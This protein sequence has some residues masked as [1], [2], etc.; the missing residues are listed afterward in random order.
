MDGGLYALVGI[1]VSGYDYSDYHTQTIEDTEYEFEITGGKANNIGLL[2]WT[3]TA[4]PKLD[5]DIVKTAEMSQSLRLKDAYEITSTVEIVKGYDEARDGFNRRVGG[6]DW[7]PWVNVEVH[8]AGQPATGNSGTPP[9]AA[10]QPQSDPNASDGNEPP[11]NTEIIFF[12][13]LTSHTYPF[14]GATLGLGFAHKYPLVPGWIS[15][16]FGLA[17]GVHP[18]TFVKILKAVWDIYQV[19]HPDEHTSD[20]DDDTGGDKDDDDYP[21]CGDY[22]I[23]I[24]NDFTFGS[25]T[26]R[27]FF[28]RAVLSYAYKGRS[29][30]AANWITGAEI[31]Y[32]RAGIGIEFAY[33]MPD[34]FATHTGENW[35][36]AA[37]NLHL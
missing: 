28:G 29:D 16:G 24:F 26:L 37:L 4:R 23:K 18:V 31:I 17:A 22:V 7:K 36:R 12:L 33:M 27:P 1:T 5:R 32:T 15:P 21:W 35:F 9:Q 6:L 30:S 19:L 13:N 34:N 14:S 20:D 11:G 3:I 10:A 2:W 25:I 8:T